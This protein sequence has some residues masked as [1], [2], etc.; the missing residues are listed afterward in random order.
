MN[1]VSD[2][3]QI[4]G[5]FSLLVYRRQ[6]DSN[7]SLVSQTDVVR[8]IG[9]TLKRT[10][11]DHTRRRLHPEEQELRVD[12]VPIDDAPEAELRRVD[13]PPSVRTHLGKPSYCS[14]RGKYDV[15]S[16]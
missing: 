15:E 3:F 5:D 8:H 11:L 1:S 13:K 7:R 14:L 2:D 16:G 4:A 12:L 9:L 10:E 6:F